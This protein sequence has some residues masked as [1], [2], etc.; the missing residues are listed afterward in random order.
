[1]KSITGNGALTTKRPLS[2]DILFVIGGAAAILMVPLVA[3]Q[4]TPE[5]NWTLSDFVIMGV[6][7][8]GVGLMY[9]TVS[10]NLT[11]PRYRLAVG[12]GL[13]FALMLMWVEL[14]VG[15]FGSPFA[16]S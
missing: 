16:G 13:A 9:V 10:R 6:L 7:L 1:M 14:A 3:M 5:V 8:V 12:V 4:L 15:V 2:H 11:N